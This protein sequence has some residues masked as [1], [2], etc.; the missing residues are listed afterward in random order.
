MSIHPLWKGW[1]LLFH[2]GSQVPGTY[3]NVI[4]NQFNWDQVKR[5]PGVDES[6][7]KNKIGALT[8]F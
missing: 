6:Q 3:V 4:V 5:E 1:G 8:V 2:Y 7:L